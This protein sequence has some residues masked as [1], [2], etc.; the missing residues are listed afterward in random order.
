MPCAP[1][2]SK[3]HK[4]LYPVPKLIYS[5]ALIKW[6]KQNIRKKYINFPAVSL[7]QKY[8]DTVPPSCLSWPQQRPMRRQYSHPRY[9]L[10]FYIFI[11]TSFHFLIWLLLPELQCLVSR[12]LLF[13]ICEV[14]S[15]LKWGSV[16]R[17]CE[18]TVRCSSISLPQ[19]ARIHPACLLCFP[20][21]NRTGWGWFSIWDSRTRIKEAS[22]T[23]LIYPQC[24]ANP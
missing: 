6:P 15:I 5:N 22:I 9:C 14:I 4:Q 8:S 24:F 7:E 16:V 11:L 13:W 18:P 20:G 3:N 10:G 12:L 21:G 19:T 17:Q 2:C 23:L 1:D